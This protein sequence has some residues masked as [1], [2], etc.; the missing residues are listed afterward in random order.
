MLYLRGKAPKATSLSLAIFITRKN[1]VHT[2]KYVNTKICAG[3]GNGNPL[4]YSYLEVPWM[5]KPGRLQAMGSQ[6]VRHD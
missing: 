2:S 3:E 5:E 6:R 1:L 4:Q